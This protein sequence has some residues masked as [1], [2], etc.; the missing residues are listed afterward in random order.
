V[1]HED[2]GFRMPRAQAGGSGTPPTSAIIEYPP[3]YTPG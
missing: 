3:A 2:S 1:T